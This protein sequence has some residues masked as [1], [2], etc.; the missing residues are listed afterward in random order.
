[1]KSYDLTYNRFLAIK[2]IKNILQWAAV[3]SNSS[4]KNTLRKIPTEF[5]SIQQRK[6]QSES[7]STALGSLSAIIV[8]SI[9]PIYLFWKDRFGGLLFIRLSLL[10]SGRCDDTRRANVIGRPVFRHF[11]VEESYTIVE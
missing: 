9:F 2:I 7:N 11:E 4:R 5:T 6:Q 8:P 1:M 3:N 10:F